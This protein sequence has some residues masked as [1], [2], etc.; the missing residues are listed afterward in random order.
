MG[1]EE[2]WKRGKPGKREK[3]KG[4]LSLILFPMHDLTTS[5]T[6]T[7]RN[8]YSGLFYKSPNYYTSPRLIPS[9]RL[10]KF[11]SFNKYQL[12]AQRNQRSTIWSQCCERAQN[13]WEKAEA[14]TTDVENNTSD[15][16]SNEERAGNEKA[17]GQVKAK[18]TAHR[19]DG[20][21]EASAYR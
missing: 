15:V 12:L 20:L 21:N 8:A 18:P 13:S 11:L 2:V 17:T 6:L 19:W 5:R 10:H 7:E 1:K 3:G 14:D 16:A 9:N 4:T